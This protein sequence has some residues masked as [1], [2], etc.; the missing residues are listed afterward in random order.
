VDELAVF[1]LPQPAEST[2]ALADSTLVYAKRAPYPIRLPGRLLGEVKFLPRFG[3]NLLDSRQNPI[4]L[5]SDATHA[6]V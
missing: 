3:L 2:L 5:L 4:G 1:V 6:C